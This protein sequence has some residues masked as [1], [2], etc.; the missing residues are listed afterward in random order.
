[1]R[2]LEDKNLWCR[3][4]HVYYAECAC[5]FQGDAAGRAK[6]DVAHIQYNQALRDI[7]AYWKDKVLNDTAGTNQQF[8]VI[9]H[10]F[11]EASDIPSLAYLSGLDC[12][13]PSALAHENF[14][15]ASWNSLFVPLSEK[16]TN[17]NFK[18]EL[19]CPGPEDYIRLD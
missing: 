11:N 6:M 12:F 8:A 1:V 18:P 9:Y 2:L 16:I 19:F 13:H 5:I 4:L 14:A 7:Q 17:W 3:A 10:P 15:I